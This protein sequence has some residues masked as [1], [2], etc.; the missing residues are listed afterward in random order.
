MSHHIGFNL[1]LIK[2]YISKHWLIHLNR[3]TLQ[4]MDLNNF[5]LTQSVNICSLLTFTQ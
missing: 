2:Q 3:F 5:T 1:V 4:K